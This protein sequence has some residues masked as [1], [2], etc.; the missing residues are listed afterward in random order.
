MRVSEPNLDR[1]RGPGR[2]KTEAEMVGLL[3]HPQV[4]L[5][6]LFIVQWQHVGERTNAGKT[7]IFLSSYTLL[8]CRISLINLNIV[9]VM[10]SFPLFL[11]LSISPPSLVEIGLDILG[12]QRK[13]SLTTHLYAHLQVSITS[14]HSQSS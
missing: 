10:I 5:T 3:V 8:T 13:A 1:E 12:E 14:A 6:L 2:T 11:C 9:M 4:P 7:V